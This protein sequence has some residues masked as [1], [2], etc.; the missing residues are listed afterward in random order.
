[1]ARAWPI[2]FCA[3]D[4]KATSS[5]RNGAIPVHSEFRQPRISSSSAISSSACALTSLLQLLLERITVDAVVV[6]LE[7]VDELV[8][9]VHGLAR[10]DP[11]SDRLP[12]PAVL[13]ARVPLGELLVRRLD[14]AGVRERLPFSLLTKN[15]VD[16][17]ASGRTTRRTHSVSPRVVR[18][19]PSRSSVFGP[20]PVTTCLS[21]SQSG[22]ENPQTPSSSFRSFGSGTVSPSSQICGTYPSRNCWRASPL[23]WL[24]IRQMY[25]GSSSAGIGFPWNCISGPHQRSSASWTSS[26][27]SSVP[28]IIVR[29]TSRPWRMWNDSS[30]QIFFMI[31]AY[32]A[33]EHLRS[34]F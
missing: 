30:Q 4:E 13:L 26:R 16:H 33:Y 15:L 2:S 23:P 17:A 8:D 1:M 9:L 22:S 7:L 31:R 21:S 10:H 34:A 18:R 25:I 29:I 20:W 27:C 6:P 28:F 24:L 3:F 32:G 12:A 14:R 5:S 11:Q 19:S